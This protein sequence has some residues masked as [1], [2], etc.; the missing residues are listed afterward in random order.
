M[1][2]VRNKYISRKDF[3]SWTNSVFKLCGWNVLNYNLFFSRP[4]WNI[5]LDFMVGKKR[6]FIELPKIQNNR[7]SVSSVSL[8]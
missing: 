1:Y 5:Y 8:L 6:W 7:K 4:S 2:N 3:S